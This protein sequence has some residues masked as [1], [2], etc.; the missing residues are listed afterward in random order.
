MR[1]LFGIRNSCD[2]CSLLW[3]QCELMMQT[4]SRALRLIRKTQ[5]LLHTV[6]RYEADENLLHA[7]FEIKV[8]FALD[9]WRWINGLDYNA[10]MS[11]KFCVGAEVELAMTAQ[12]SSCSREIF[13]AVSYCYLEFYSSHMF[14]A[15]SRQEDFIK[16]DLVVEVRKIHEF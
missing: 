4:R 13:V 5:T 7:D 2:E 8:W 12:S 15:L 10:L 14:F 9:V 1:L 6:V 3:A 16:I 11:L